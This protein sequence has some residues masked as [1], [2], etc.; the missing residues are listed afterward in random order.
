[1]VE[2]LF[3]QFLAMLKFINREQQLDLGTIL[4][5][6][7]GHHAAYHWGTKGNIT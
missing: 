2:F 6:Y 3:E 7:V 5:F 1:M 4:L